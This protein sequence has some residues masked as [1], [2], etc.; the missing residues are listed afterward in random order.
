MGNL[1]LCSDDS[2]YREFVPNYGHDSSHLFPHAPGRR[3]GKHRLRF[4]VTVGEWIREKIDEPDFPQH[5]GTSSA[6]SAGAIPAVD[7]NFDGYQESKLVRFVEVRLAWR[8]AKGKLS[9]MPIAQSAGA[10]ATISQYRI[11]PTRLKGNGA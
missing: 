2:C 11:V 3:D 7:F 10:V 9:A 8:T 4:I 6:K 5:Y 1:H